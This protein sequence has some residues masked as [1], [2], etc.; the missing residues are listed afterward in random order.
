MS[1]S[2]DEM[3]RQK[4]LNRCKPEDFDGHTDFSRLSAVERLRWLSR[5]THF[6]YTLA[7]N[8]SD[9]Q[10]THFFEPPQSDG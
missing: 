2:D 5:T 9:L 10:C 7:R 1:R 6:I 8:N 4:L 3:R